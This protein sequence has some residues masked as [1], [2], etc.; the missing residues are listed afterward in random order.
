MERD[1]EVIDG[2]IDDGRVEDRHDRPQHHHAGDDQ[3]L[4]IEPLRLLRLG[5]VGLLPMTGHLCHVQIVADRRVRL[6][7]ILTLGVSFGR[8]SIT[9]R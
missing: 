4:A 3:R 7:L 8:P 9:G 2:D 6:F 1:R 5:V